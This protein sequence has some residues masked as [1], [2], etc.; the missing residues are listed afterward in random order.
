MTTCYL[1]SK[2]G[3]SVC[4]ACHGRQQEQSATR[5]PVCNTTLSTYIPNIA[6]RN[7]ARAL[8]CTCKYCRSPLT[9]E[10]IVA[11]EK[12]C[13]EIPVQCK[14]CPEKIARNLVSSHLCPNET[15]LCACG[16]NVRRVEMHRHQTQHCP[17]LPASCPLACGLELGR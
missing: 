5:C 15:C 8:S 2:C 9:V 11:H 14:T 13:A 4:G 7:T 17:C 16:A 12:S 10:D 6:L 3:H 1:V